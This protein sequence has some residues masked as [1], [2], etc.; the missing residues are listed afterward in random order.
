MYRQQRQRK[1]QVINIPLMETPEK[2][3]NKVTYHNN[4]IWFFA[5]VDKMTC[6]DLLTCLNELDS[7]GFSHINLY[8]NSYGGVLTEGFNIVGRILSMKTPVH[9][10]ICGTAASSATI[11]SVACQKRFIFKYSHMLIHQLSGGVV[12]KYKEMDDEIINCKKFMKTIQKIYLK[13]TKLTQEELKELL[14]SDLW[15]DAEECLQ[16]GLVD[17]I[18]DENNKLVSPL[19][20]IDLFGETPKETSDKYLTS[21][22]GDLYNSYDYGINDYILPVSPKKS[23]EQEFELKPLQVETQNKSCSER[24]FEHLD[25]IYY[26]LK[27]ITKLRIKIE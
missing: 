11:I 25:S 1:Q 20:E 13:H 3:T 18:I 19:N 12:G 27:N 14:N 16:Y 21:S 5:D 6:Y 2:E 17:E 8:I 23:M 26:V 4:E 9:S 10:Y 15:Q 7:K 22:K 24:L